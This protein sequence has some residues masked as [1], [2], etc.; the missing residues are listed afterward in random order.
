MNC[1]SSYIISAPP[2]IMEAGERLS[3]SGP[4]TSTISEEEQVVQNISI[5]HFGGKHIG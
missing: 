5:A 4:L 2:E 3:Q 1:K